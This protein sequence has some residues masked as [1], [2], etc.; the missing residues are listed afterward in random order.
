MQGLI[1]LLTDFTAF[2]DDPPGLLYNRQAPDFSFQ[3]NVF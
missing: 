3:I 2:P 1:W